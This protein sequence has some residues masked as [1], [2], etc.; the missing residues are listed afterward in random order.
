LH[1]IEFVTPTHTRKVLRSTFPAAGLPPLPPASTLMKAFDERRP[2]VAT[3]PLRHGEYVRVFLPLSRADG[4][5]AGLLALG[6]LVPGDTADRLAE[7]R[8]GY[9][10]YRQLRLFQNP[11]KVTLLITLFLVTLLIL[12]AATWFGFRLAKGITEPVGMLAEAT[13]RVAAGDLDF[14]LEAEGRDELSSLVRAFNIMTQDLREAKRRAEAASQELRRSNVE[15]DQR[16]RYMEIILHNVAAG[17]IS[18]DRD[19]VVT[20]MNRSAEAILGVSA[21]EA[22]GRA[23]F[24]LLTPDQ[25]EQFDEI[26]E[27]LTHS[28]RGTL[29]RPVRLNSGDRLLSLLMSFTLLRDREGRSL[30]VV[31]VF[32]D[33]T[34]L[35]KI[36]RLAAWREVARRIAHE[37]KNPLTPIQL[38]AERLRK[39]YLDR[40][41]EDA[42]EV[43]D[44]C[45]RVIITQVEELK[46]LVNEFSNFARMP[47][48]RLR[49]TD[50]RA[51]AE[52]VAA[53]YREGHP[54]VTFEVRAEGAVPE[55]PLDRDQVKR[56]LINL[57]DNAVAAL[58]EAGT[59]TLTIRRSEEAPEVQLEVA[60]TGRGVPEPDKARLFEPYFSTKRGGTGLGLAIVNSIVADH[61]GRILVEDNV[62]RGTRFILCF[63]LENPA[64]ATGRQTAA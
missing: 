24:E 26:R 45:T 39:R 54:R 30:G 11:I 4:E 44:R 29:Q 28:P 5:V 53:L 12:F 46:R 42:R 19:G 17:V 62:P 3:A 1:S 36:Q 59:I 25:V 51:L 56:A 47:S 34:E 40:L 15:L 63:P 57:L 14:T 16:R 38:S 41:D 2:V 8:L 6:S 52:E 50:L 60:D 61:N 32:D 9:E 18:I 31:V 20:T 23:Y 33:L 55:I 21:A 10:D 43:F 58:A 13:H 35:E 7:I 37:V 48:L 22:V 64:E 27:A 49:P